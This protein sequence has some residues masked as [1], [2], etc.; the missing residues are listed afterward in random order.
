LQPFSK[1]KEALLHVAVA[2]SALNK[3]PDYEAFLGDDGQPQKYL[4][5]VENYLPEDVLKKRK[6]AMM[7]DA[8]SQQKWDLSAF[9]FQ[10]RPKDF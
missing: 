1:G 5:R 4:Y 6:W 3:L 8:G 7:T 10:S 9:C 2:V